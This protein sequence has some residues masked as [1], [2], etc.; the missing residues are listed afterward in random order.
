MIF[1][2]GTNIIAQKNVANDSLKGFDSIDVKQFVVQ[3]N[4]NSSEQSIYISKKKTEYKNLKYNIL[5]Q[6]SQN[7]KFTSSS[8]AIMAGNLDFEAGNLSGWA[9]STSTN[10][11]S[12]PLQTC[13]ISPTVN[14]IA[15]NG[16]FDPNFG[17][18]LNSPLGGNWVARL[19]P[20]SLIGQR[21]TSITNTL[22]VTA[23]NNY[24]KIAAK[25]VLEVATHSCDAQPFINLKVT[26]LS[27]NVVIFNKFIQ[28]NESS[29]G[30]CNGSNFLS[31]TPGAANN[32]SYNYNN[33]W[34]VYCIDLS[35]S[36][37]NSVKIELAASECSY[38]GHGGYGYFDVINTAFS[39]TTNTVTINNNSYS[40]TSQP[41][42]IGVCNSNT[43][44]AI[45]PSAAASYTWFGTGINGLNTQSVQIN[46]P[47]S[48]SVVSTMTNNNGC[49]NLN[50]NTSVNFTVGTISPIN[51]TSSSTVSCGYTPV[52]FSLSGASNYSIT[53]TSGYN[54]Y[55]SFSNIIVTPTIT[56]SFYIN[57]FTSLGCSATQTINV[58]VAPIPTITILGNNFC[59]GNTGT[60]TAT[61]ADTYV[62]I[63]AAMTTTVS[64]T[65]QLIITPTA[66]TA[67]YV[68]GTNTLTGCVKTNVVYTQVANTT[69][70]VSS[71]PFICQGAT[72]TLY[73]SGGI[74]NT[75]TWSTGSTAN[76]ITL[77][78]TV[79]TTY[80]L[81]SNNACGNISTP[82]T[83]TVQSL[84]SLSI[85][86][87]TSICPNQTYTW[88]ANG[89]YTYVFTGL[90]FAT[91]PTFIATVN[92]NSTP[93]INLVGTDIYNC[94]STTTLNLTILS[95][96][97]FSV[98][99]PLS[100]CLGNTVT[101]NASGASTYTWNTGANANS[102]SISP[103]VNTCYSFTATGANGCIA[104]WNNCV[105][106]NNTT[107]TIVPIQSSYTAC[108]GGAIYF[109]QNACCGNSF[110]VNNQYFSNYPF[111]YPPASGL[112]TLSV[113]N[114]CGSDQAT[115]S[116]TVFPVPTA[117]VSGIDSACYLSQVT[118]TLSGG[119][120]YNCYNPSV[121]SFTTAGPLSTF[122]LANS[123]YISV[124][125]VSANGCAGQYFNKYV[126][127]I[128]PVFPY[129]TPTSATVCAG[130]SI[131][132]TA[133]ASAPSFTWSNN[134]IGNSVTLT[135]TTNTSI[136]V[137]CTG[138]NGCLGT[139][140]KN[141]FVI[142]IPTINA[143]SSPTAICIGAATTLSVS[144][145]NSYTWSNNFIGNAQTVTPTVTGSYSVTGTATNNPCPA[146]TTV[147][148]IVNQLPL[149]GFNQPQY[150]LCSTQNAV[151]T[152]TGAASYNIGPGPVY[153]FTLSN[154]SNSYT[155]QVIGYSSAGCQNTG[156]VAINVFPNPVIVAPS[157]TTCMG[158]PVTLTAT[159]ANTYTWSTGAFTDTITVNPTSFTT[160]AVMGADLNGCTNS[161]YTSVF[162]YSVPTL[163][164]NASPSTICYG[165]S[166]YLTVSGSSTYTWSNGSNSTA[167]SITPTV[168]TV[169]TVSSFNS[170]CV[171]SKTIAVTVTT[172]T[173]IAIT[174]TNICIGN[175]A[176]LYASGINSYSWSTGSNNPS[177]TITPT[178]TTAYTLTGTDINGCVGTTVS[179]VTLNPLPTLTVSSTAPIL[180]VGQLAV[181][182]ASG[183]NTY[184]WVNLATG[185]SINV[186]PSTNTT[187]TI[188][189]KDANNCVNSTTFTQ[190]VTI[191]TGMENLTLNQSSSIKIYPNPSKGIFNISCDCICDNSTLEVYN[192]LGQII[193]KQKIN[194]KNA[195]VDISQYAAGLYYLKVK[196]E[197]GEEVIKIIK[198]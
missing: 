142:A 10:Q 74:S 20:T 73:A 88:V 85:T 188:I 146:T 31:Q 147:N 129:I 116:L 105:Q 163:A 194:S 167:F 75:Y 162:V 57:G 51:V 153:T 71:S 157:G 192:T 111:F 28:A 32:V 154:P 11:L 184:T 100:I 117:S 132:L 52:S 121:G 34:D 171:V 143:I 148:V 98:N 86:G 173:S 114:G 61:G 41:F 6:V 30:S 76:G 190:S 164:V 67:Y 36:I 182:T 141:I 53:S 95:S 8:N 186:I 58:A 102:I 16:G 158:S 29:F 54:N 165:N 64:T 7:N 90:A 9:T 37:G 197:N 119:T 39:P 126:K 18:S 80:T 63:D 21:Y 168:S 166:T 68:I 70:S 25:Y 109:S 139:T 65:N 183:A 128:M 140:Y 107:P 136:T 170:P 127:A 196:T 26:D 48:Y 125:A 159:G 24:I 187:Y 35:A 69:L 91:G 137:S 82:F 124:Q 22:N 89:A 172:N 94:Q 49:S 15:L 175:S 42:N 145:A 43:A 144:G 156:S 177:I 56:S 133:T 179:T 59:A 123:G 4:L 27:G 112:Y 93:Y 104:S 46:Q 198:E 189:G 2:S 78:P 40:V 193:F 79:T 152:V 99:N 44:I 38:A 81:S 174:N 19:N 72:I 113:S 83:L 47:G 3:N 84:P 122:T 108:A 96:P 77:S 5:P 106:V 14:A 195:E 1:L 17:F 161:Q 191:C 131:V 66:S 12:I 62:W 50:N 160:Y 135:P 120:T 92:S 150:S 110:F 45:A 13:C 181:L 60:M 97:T 176:T 185:P 169:Y 118:L 134:F 23:S 101:L 87:P 151:I 55:T 155:L 149:V 130:S 178:A 180:C 33:N 138:T 103:T 115:F